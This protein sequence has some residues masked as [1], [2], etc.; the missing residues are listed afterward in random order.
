MSDVLP[1][2]LRR[3]SGE[4]LTV[5]AA[6]YDL[7]WTPPDGARERSAWVALVLP[8][9]AI[10]NRKALAHLRR[11]ADDITEIAD[12]SRDWI[13]PD[14]LRHFSNLMEADLDHPDPWS[15][16]LWLWL[17]DLE[18]HK[19]CARRAQVFDPYGRPKLFTRFRCQ[20]A[21]DF[22]LSDS[23]FGPFV[24]EL[25]TLYRAHDFSGEDIIPTP[26]WE[27]DDDGQ[28]TGLTLHAEV[29][30]LPSFEANINETG[31]R[32]D[33]LLRKPTIW[34]CRFEF[35]SG[36]LDLY[37]DRGGWCDACVRTAS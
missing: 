31:E 32:D 33:L 37:C 36:Q 34:R 22:F 4:L 2:L 14:L 11:D 28:R 15:R 13:F 19:W 7:F 1:T 6:R 3:A 18:A 23:A 20:P 5:W 35:A 12:P 8:E 24:D 17:N 16:A 9:L 26:D 27:L 21:E 30:R 29:A 25:K 10:N